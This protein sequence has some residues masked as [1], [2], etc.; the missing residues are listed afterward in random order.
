MQ[1][2]SF[3]VRDYGVAEQAYQTVRS[4]VTL[5]YDEHKWV[6]FSCFGDTGHFVPG[7]KSVGEAPLPGAVT[8]Y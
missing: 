3:S 7:V 1:Q 8:G 4:R 2:F 6:P 5:T